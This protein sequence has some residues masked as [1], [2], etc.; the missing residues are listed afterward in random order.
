M[1]FPQKVSG[2][3]PPEKFYCGADATVLPRCLIGRS[4][5]C[6][7]ESSSPVSELQRPC[8]TTE[9]WAQRLGPT[10]V[11][12]RVHLHVC[13]DSFGPGQT[14]PGLWIFT[15]PT[16]NKELCSTPH[17]G[18]VTDVLREFVPE[19]EFSQSHAVR[20]GRVTGL[21]SGLRGFQPYII[22][23]SFAPLVC[24][25]GAETSSTKW[26]FL[27]YYPR[28]PSTRLILFS[29]VKPTCLTTV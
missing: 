15:S 7:W 9:L 29:R 5:R 8:P 17:R 16:H 26:E 13:K 11:L 4:V 10:R 22:V 24:Q 2:R 6:A 27:S 14:R 3:E 25:P 18:M 12:V 1:H 28:L 23:R 19:S 20:H 21:S